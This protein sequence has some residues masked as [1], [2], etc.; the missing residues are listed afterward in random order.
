MKPTFFRTP[1]DF[2]SWLESNHG[3]YAELQLGFYKK[4]SGHASITY[5]EALDLALCYGWID[6]V[7]KRIDNEAYTIRFTPRKQKSKWSAVN[8]RRVQQLTKQGLM[9]QAGLAVFAGAEDQPRSYSYEQRNAARL[10]AAQEKL[11]R[12]NNEAWVFFQA[13]PFWY[14]R[15]ATWWVISAKKEETR[16]RRLAQLISAS[17]RRRSIAAVPQNRIA[18][19]TVPNRHRK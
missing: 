4:D 6:G 12:S 14:R 13:Q 3:Q 11:F 8:I 17:A 18:S 10:D 7:R 5:A 2:R 19:G 16:Q 9:H 15:T 1:S